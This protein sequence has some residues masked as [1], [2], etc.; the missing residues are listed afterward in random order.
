[1]KN[2]SNIENGKNHVLIKDFKTGPINTSVRYCN[3]AKWFLAL[4]KLSM[5]GVQNK[6]RKENAM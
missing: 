1:L 3:I 6:L 4:L 5:I 2:S